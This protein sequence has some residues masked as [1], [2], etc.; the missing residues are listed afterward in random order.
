MLSVSSSGIAALL[1]PGGKTAHSTFKIP[2]DPDQH[3]VCNFKKDSTRADL[4]R[5]ASLIIWDEALM[6]C[7]LAFEAVYRHFK[8]ICSDNRVFGGKLVVLGGDFRQILPVVPDEGRESIVA[9][10][11]HQASFWR[12]YQVM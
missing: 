10:T 7:R 8:D 4:I 11:L 2:F 12:D 5:E 1:F 6:T 3:S 9:A